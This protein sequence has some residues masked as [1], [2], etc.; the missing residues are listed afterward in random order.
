MTGLVT[1]EQQLKEYAFEYMGN[2]RR[3]GASISIR[4]S[5][6]FAISSNLE[7]LANKTKQF[8]FTQQNGLDLFKEFE[9]LTLRASL[10][11]L[12]FMERRLSRFKKC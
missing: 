4:Q 9:R 7:K 11:L 10:G 5:L 2:F 6:F 12:L 8:N 1:V 3:D